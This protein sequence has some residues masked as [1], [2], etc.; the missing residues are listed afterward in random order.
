MTRMILTMLAIFGAGI[1]ID[2]LVTRYTSAIADKKK[3]HASILAMIITVLNF[4]VIAYILQNVDGNFGSILSFAGGNGI[5]TFL[6][7][8]KTK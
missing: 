3:I 5:G 2:I 7:F 6:G 8:G 1:F 4:T